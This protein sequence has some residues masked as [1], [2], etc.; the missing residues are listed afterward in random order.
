MSASL[1]SLGIERLSIEERLRLV[2]ELWD[3]I[4][5]ATPLT[6]AQR[7]E[8]DRRLAEHEANPDDVVSW[9]NIKA[10]ITARLK[11]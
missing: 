6:D 11:R 9:E 3:S 8:L 7:A 10:S 1:K 5:E 4:A 2:E